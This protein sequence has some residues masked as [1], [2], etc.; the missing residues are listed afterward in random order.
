[1]HKIKSSD[2]TNRFFSPSGISSNNRSSRC[3]S[4]TDQACLYVSGFTFLPPPPSSSFSAEP[5]LRIRGEAF[6]GVKG[7]GESGRG[8]LGILIVRGL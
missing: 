8:R 7:G 5:M 3:C 6:A 1:M 2:N 4:E